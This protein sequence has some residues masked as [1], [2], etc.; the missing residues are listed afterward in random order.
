MEALTKSDRADEAEP[1]V[2]ALERHGR[3]LDRAWTP[4]VGAR[5]RAMALAAHGDAKAAEM[6]NRDAAAKLFVSAKTVEATL[7]RVYRQLGIRSRAEPAQRMNTT[8]K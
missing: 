1:L 7:A 4:A 8:E 2:D 5:C 3:R 6:T